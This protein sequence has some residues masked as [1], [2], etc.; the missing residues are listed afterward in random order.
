MIFGSLPMTYLLAAV[1]IIG[2]IVYMRI[3][4][5]VNGTQACLD[6]AGQPRKLCKCLPG[7]PGKD[8]TGET[9]D[10]GRDC[11]LVILPDNKGMACSYDQDAVKKDGSGPPRPTWA[12]TL[13]EIWV[14]M[15]VFALSAWTTYNFSSNI[16]GVLFPAIFIFGGMLFVFLRIFSYI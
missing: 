8:A 13:T 7:Q 12:S 1:A 11:N 5:P 3:V 9:G 15:I 10:P 6:L 2:T 14:Y 16:Y 4:N